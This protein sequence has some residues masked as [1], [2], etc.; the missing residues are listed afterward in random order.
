MLYEKELPQKFKGFSLK[1]FIEKM[2]KGF[3]PYVVR[4]VREIISLGNI[5]QEFSEDRLPTLD[6]VFRM[7]GIAT[8]RLNLISELYDKVAYY[9][10]SMLRPRV[11]EL[12]HLQELSK[13]QMNLLHQMVKGYMQKAAKEETSAQKEGEPC[14]L[15]DSGS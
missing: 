13:N 12:A 1:Y 4:R 3:K 10:G 5:T 6:E 2:D 15:E 7:I 14:K 11:I 8:T 9:K